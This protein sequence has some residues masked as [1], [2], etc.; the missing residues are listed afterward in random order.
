MAK[1]KRV[2]LWIFGFLVV[3]LGGCLAAL[4]YFVSGMCA[5]TVFDQI[6]SP[7]KKLKAVIYQID[8]GATTD[9]NT[10]VAIVRASFDTSDAQSLPKGAF[11][12]DRNHGRA[13]AGATRGPEVLLSWES[14]NTLSLQHHQFARVF[15]SEERQGGV[16]IKYQ[17]FQ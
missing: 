16:T 9:F 12:A 1:W 2:L 7:N 11:V 5:T 14:D 10:H 15:R 13:P 4:N 8:C 6:L 3:T 17:T